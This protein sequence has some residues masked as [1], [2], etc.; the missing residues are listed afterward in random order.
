M[1]S[2]C[3]LIPLDAPIFQFQFTLPHGERPVGRRRNA[4]RSRFNSRS[5]MGSDQ[6]FSVSLL[7]TYRFNSRS[8]MGSDRQSIP[9]PIPSTCFNSRSRMGSDRQGHFYQHARALFQ[10]TLPHGERR[11]R[12]GRGQSQGG[13]NSRSRMGSDTFTVA[14]QRVSRKFQFTLPHGERLGGP[15][16]LTEACGGFNSRS[17]MGSDSTPSSPNP[18]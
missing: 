12:G 16:P 7:L 11:G 6:P 5:R 10:F 1:G 3:S 8:R 2:D 14:F 17:R 18:G 9:P 13:F 4:H 15:P